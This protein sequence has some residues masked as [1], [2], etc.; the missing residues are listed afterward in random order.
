MS[1]HTP[2]KENAMSGWHYPNDGFGPWDGKSFEPD[3]PTAADLGDPHF[4]FWAEVAQYPRGFGPPWDGEDAP[5][6][7]GHPY[8]VDEEQTPDPDRYLIDPGF[9]EDEG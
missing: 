7:S 6:Q 5:S 8:Y 2:Q 9:S 1:Y 3:R 4:E